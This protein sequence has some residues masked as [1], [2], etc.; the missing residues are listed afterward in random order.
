VHIIKKGEKVGASE[1]ALLNM[2]N[3]TPFSYGL[4]IRVSGVCSAYTPLCVCL[5]GVR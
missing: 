2:L 5:D 4:V 1:A 3:I